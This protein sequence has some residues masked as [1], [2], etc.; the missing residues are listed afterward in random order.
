PAD[1]Q[2]L[3]KSIKISYLHPQEGRSLF[4]EAQEKLKNRLL[5]NWGR[6]STITTSLKK[7]Q[8]DWEAL[9]KIAKTYLSTS[10][11]SSIQKMWPGSQAS[12]ELPSKIL[13]IIAI[14]DIS[15]QGQKTLPEIQLTLQGTGAQST[16]LYLIHF[17]LDSDRSLHLGEYN[18]IW[19]LEEPESFLHA[20]LIIKLAK[21]LSSK[22]WLD[23][24][25][26]IISTHSPILLATSRAGGSKIR[27]N[28]IKN[29]A[30]QTNK[31]AINWSEKEINDIGH[32][33]GDI[34]FYAY[35]L[36]AA[37]KKPI[38]IEDKKP[39]TIIKFKE[40]GIDIAQGLGGTGE[41]AKYLEVYGSY[42][43][44]LKTAAYFIL[45]CDLGKK[46][47][48]RFLTQ[49][50]E[51]CFGYVKYKVSDNVFAITLP[52]NFSSEDLF[53]EFDN[54][55][56]ECIDKIWNTTSWGIK[57][58]IPSYLSGVVSAVRNKSFSNKNEAKQ[59]IK[60]KEDI[61]SS[62]WRKVERDHLKISKQKVKPLK[63]LLS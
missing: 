41:I 24:I 19:L 46:D 1:I 62:F 12:I 63:R 13:D 9:R 44:L 20:D 34:N 8:T 28:L 52:E 61:K 40:A 43:S 53:D 48:S 42:H 32:M 58:D 18:P 31:T 14:S 54:H 25:Q 6:H 35:F 4:R 37:N 57:E 55:L 3:L 45:D 51:E 21:E 27:W 29:H 50:I 17:L 5:A 49:Q 10:L 59:F 33:M 16:I 23:N 47:L 11:T 22:E 56:E 60:N 26:M 2:R 30:L 39:L 15:F 7:L 38:F 36:A